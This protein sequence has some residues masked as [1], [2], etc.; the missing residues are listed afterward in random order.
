MTFYNVFEKLSS[1]KLLKKYSN[2]LNVFE[3]T[4]ANKLFT[5]N[6]FNLAIKIEENKQPLFGSV[7][8]LFRLELE[9][10]CRYIKKNIRKNLYCT[11]EF[12]VKS[13]YPIYKKE[14]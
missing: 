2:F 8:K 4:C 10:L 13:I 11:L 1:I 3:K 7:Y 12:A 9:V 5:Y 6:K 14:K